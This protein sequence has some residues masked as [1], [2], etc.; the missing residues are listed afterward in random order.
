MRNIIY[1]SPI[2]QANI[3]LTTS[4]TRYI[5]WLITAMLINKQCNGFSMAVSNP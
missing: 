5:L 3:K 1:K 4:Y 2:R